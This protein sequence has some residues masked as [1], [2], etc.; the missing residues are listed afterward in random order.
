M[1]FVDI[2]QRDDVPLVPPKCDYTV[3]WCILFMFV[4]GKH[5]IMFNH[6]DNY[7]HFQNRAKTEKSPLTVSAYS[8]WNLAHKLH[9][10]VEFGYSKSKT[11]RQTQFDSGT[12]W[13]K[14]RGQS[15]DHTW[16]N[17]DVFVICKLF[18]SRAKKTNISEQPFN[19]LPLV[20]ASKE[21]EREKDERKT[22]SVI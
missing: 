8:L 1:H 5:F 19:C 4:L 3:Y 13:T 22:Q 10:H 16:R 20:R 7:V 15:P 9:K 14:A 6:V 17:F 21:S 2:I 11:N 18:F 12:N